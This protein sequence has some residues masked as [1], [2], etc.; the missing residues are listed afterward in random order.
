MDENN[1]NKIAPE[2]ME[3]DSL[4]AKLNLG[5][6][7]RDENKLL[8]F[9]RNHK[10]VKGDGNEE[11]KLE[12]E[13]LFKH[14]LIALAIHFMHAIIGPLSIPLLYLI[15]GRNRCLNMGFG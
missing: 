2:C 3:I 11:M 7:S 1:C 9:E 5:E 10:N 6:T 4:D 8:R 15:F 13:F 14:V 12:I